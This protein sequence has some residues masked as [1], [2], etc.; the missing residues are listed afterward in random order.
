[1]IFSHIDTSHTRIWDHGWFDTSRFAVSE[2]N[3][4]SPDAILSDFTDSP[5]FARSFCESPDPWGKAI[6]RHGPF[7]RNHFKYDW[8]TKIP[9]V[10]LRSTLHET[11]LSYDFEPE[12]NDEQIATI[13]YWTG[14]P[15]IVN[16]WRLDA[17]DDESIR[18]DFAHIWWAFDEFVVY[19]ATS[20]ELSIAVIGFD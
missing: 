14:S 19:N 5:P 9:V 8:Y 16:A 1:M 2:T 3:N 6:D 10:E 12:L 18:V 7:L 15:H 13:D 4:D 11:I 17:P 20:S